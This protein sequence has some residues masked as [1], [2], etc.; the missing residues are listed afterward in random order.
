MSQAGLISVTSGVLPPTVPLQFTTD[1]G[2]AVPAANNVNVLGSGT[3]TTSGAG[4]TITI[5]SV[6]TPTPFTDQAVTFSAAVNNGYFCTAALTVNLPAGATQGQ[7]VIIETATAGN[8]VIDAAPG[9]FIRMGS[10][11]STSGG[12]STSSAEGNSVYLIYRTANTSWYSI[13]TE[14]TWVLA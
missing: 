14:G 9:D 10:S 5:T 13:S 6:S 11:V 7:F 1:A 4:S 2:I 8:V 3:T 12:T